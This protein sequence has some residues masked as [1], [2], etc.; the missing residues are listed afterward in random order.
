VGLAA[1]LGRDRFDGGPLGSIRCL[2]LELEMI[3]QIGGIPIAMS[4]IDQYRRCK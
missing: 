2:L 4:A 3:P 1:D